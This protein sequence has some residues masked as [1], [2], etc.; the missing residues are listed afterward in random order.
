[1]KAVRSCNFKIVALDMNVTNKIYEM[2]R[3]YKM[4]FILGNEKTK[5]IPVRGRK[6]VNSTHII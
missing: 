5:Q 1:M 6:G 4:N 3:V 2:L